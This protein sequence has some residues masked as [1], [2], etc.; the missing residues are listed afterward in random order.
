MTVAVGPSLMA[1]CLKNDGGEPCAILGYS[2]GLAQFGW[3]VHEFYL[4]EQ[5]HENEKPDLSSVVLLHR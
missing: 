2:P 3:G 4:G 1:G 5:K